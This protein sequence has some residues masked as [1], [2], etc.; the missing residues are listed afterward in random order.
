M[1]GVKIDFPD[2]GEIEAQA[3]EQAGRDVTDAM[4]EAT[5]FLKDTLREQVT[6]A[7]MGRRLANTWRGETYPKNRP[8]LEPAGFVWTKA[9][10]IIDAFARGATIRPVNGAKYLWLPTKNVPRKGR[11][12]KMTPDEVDSLFNAEFVIRP[13]RK[14]GVL[15]AFIEV[16]GANSGRGFRPATS[17]RLKGR[18]GLAPR[19]A[20]LVHM[21]TLIPF[22][23][24][25]KRFDL[26]GAADAAAAFFVRQISE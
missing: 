25:P 26:Q 14:R 10:K 20:R 13:S 1:L 9:P 15:L 4:R 16:V 17:R 19:Q 18:R 5:A 22:A 23:R 8:S 2:L 24:M 12:R 11:N 3:L 7:G 21:F 6:E